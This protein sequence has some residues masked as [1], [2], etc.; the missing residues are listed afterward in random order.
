MNTI[1]ITAPECKKCN[2]VKAHVDCSKIKVLD[3]SEVD[4]MAYMTYFGI[5]DDALIHLPVL[6]VDADDDETE[7]IH[8]N[9]VKIVKKIKE[10]YVH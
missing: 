10:L 1:L 9:G 5:Y 3:R 8:G 7:I 2:Y 4:A 6:I